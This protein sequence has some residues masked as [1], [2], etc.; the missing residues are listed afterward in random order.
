MQSDLDQTVYF[1]ISEALKMFPVSPDMFATIPFQIQYHLHFVNN[2]VNYCNVNVE[3]IKLK[4]MYFLF[5]GK[6]Q[7]YWFIKNL[8]KFF[9]SAV[10]SPN[11][12]SQLNALQFTVDER[13]ILWLNQFV[14]DLKQSL[15]QF[16]AVYKLNDNS[17]SDEHVDI[18]VDGLM[19]K[20]PYKQVAVRIKPFLQK[21]S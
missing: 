18:R 5:S 3:R 8:S 9:F 21:K 13:S 20:V 19:L 6:I 17:K 2:T 12:Y 4:N 10:P 7:N 15:N 1:S 16:M 11:L 14:L